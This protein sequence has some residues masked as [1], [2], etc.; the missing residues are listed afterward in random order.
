MV[1][2]VEKQIREMD[3]ESKSIHKRARE[4]AR[5]LNIPFRTAELYLQVKRR[6]YASHYEYQGELSI[7]KGFEG[8]SEKGRYFYGRINNEE[9]PEQWRELI[10]KQ[11]FTDGLNF[12]QLNG[13]NYVGNRDALEEFEFR[14]T[15]QVL[16]ERLNPLE[17]QVI[18]GRFYEGKTQKEIGIEIGITNTRVGQIEAK[19]LYKMKKK[20]ERIMRKVS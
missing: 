2:K 18:E 12:E 1:S 11:Q 14:E 19:A 3:D 8:K 9:T 4:A 17:R 5:K 13:D 6:G 10:W 15:I 7:R 20:Y 16:M